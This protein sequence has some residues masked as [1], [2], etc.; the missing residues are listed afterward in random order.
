[1]FSRATSRLLT[2]EI[3]IFYNCPP[4]SFLCL[5]DDGMHSGHHDFRNTRSTI[6]PTSALPVCCALIRLGSEAIYRSGFPG[7][8]GGIKVTKAWRIQP[9]CS[10]TRPVVSRVWAT[11]RCSLASEVIRFVSSLLTLPIGGFKPDVGRHY[12]D[13]SGARRENATV[14]IGQ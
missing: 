1:M 10:V 3:Q 14:V 4:Y 8:V 7:A 2:G 9:F 13:F 12:V 11:F 6:N 5:K